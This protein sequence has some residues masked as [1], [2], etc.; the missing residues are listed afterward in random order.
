[1]ISFTI[2]MSRQYFCENTN[3]ICL[4]NAVTCICSIALNPQSTGKVMSMCWMHLYV[5]WLK[6]GFTLEEE[7]EEKI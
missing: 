2:V 5:G 7:E 6:T 3:L 4:H 1:M